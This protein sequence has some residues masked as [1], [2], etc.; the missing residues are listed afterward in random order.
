MAAG[1]PAIGKIV[2]PAEVAAI[3]D[4]Q[5]KVYAAVNGVPTTFAV[6]RPLGTDMTGGVFFQELRPGTELT[7]LLDK[8]KCRDLLRAVGRIHRDLHRLN[9]PDLPAWDYGRYLH[10]LVTYVEWISFLRPDQRPLLDGVRDLLFRQVPDLASAHY[11]F[12]HGDFSCHQLLTDGDCWSVVDFDGCVR[13]DPHFE[14]AKLIASLKYNVPLFRDRFRVPAEPEPDL[15][16]QACA[17]YLQG[18]EEQAQHTMNRHRI[19]WY[20]I[21]WEIQ[22]LARQLKRD[23]FHPVAFARAIGLIGDLSEQLR[24]ER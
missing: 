8:D 3:Y 19:L 22:Y 14:I 15:L 7:H 11:T 18:Y 10:K 24:G 5:V 21:A 17:S 23:Q 20:R 4:R 6:A 9:V 2:R 12:C 1:A 13:G 16:E